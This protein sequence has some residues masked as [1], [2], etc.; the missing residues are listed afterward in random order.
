MRIYGVLDTF[1]LMGM[2]VNTWILGWDKNGVYA[3]IW[4][5]GVYACIFLAYMRVYEWRICVYMTSSYV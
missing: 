5:L 1:I 2:D 3:C 4:L